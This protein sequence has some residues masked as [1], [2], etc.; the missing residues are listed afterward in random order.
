MSEPFLGEIR[1]FAGNFAIRNWALCNGQ[2]LPIAQ[3]TALFSLLGVTYG[4]NGSSN[5]ALPN[6]Q[7]CAPMHWGSGPG[8]TPRVLGEQAGEAGVTLIATQM[9]AHSHGLQV[10]PRFGNQQGPTG[11]PSLSQVAGLTGGLLY[12]QPGG[13][14]PGPMNPQIATPTGGSQP[15]N[16]NQPF[17]GLTFLIA[18]QGVYPQRP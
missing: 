10:V 8:L 6:F 9:A 2:I 18:M 12:K 15:H 14:N 17:L 11:N 5:F 16:N 7:G 4:G 13:S 3:Y 1:I